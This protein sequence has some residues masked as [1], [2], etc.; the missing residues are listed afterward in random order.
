[1]LLLSIALKKYFVVRNLFSYSV[2]LAI[3]T[4]QKDFVAFIT[5]STGKILNHY[6]AVFLSSALRN[7][8]F[9]EIRCYIYYII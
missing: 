8:N 9:I 7:Y 5:V 3:T 2:H 1:M 6:D 4:L